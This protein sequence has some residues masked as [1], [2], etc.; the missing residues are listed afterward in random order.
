MPARDSTY[1]KRDHLCPMRTKLLIHVYCSH[2]WPYKSGVIFILFSA[3]F[4][5]NNHVHRT[6]HTLY[7]YFN[8][9]TATSAYRLKLVWTLQ[10]YRHTYTVRVYLMAWKIALESNLRTSFGYVNLRKK[11]NRIFIY[12][13]AKYCK[14][15]IIR[16]IPF[17]AMYEFCK[18]QKIWPSN[19][20]VHFICNGRDRDISLQLNNI[21]VRS[22]TSISSSTS[23]I[24]RNR[25][26]D[27][28]LQ[29]LNKTCSA[30][31]WEYKLESETPK[32]RYSWHNWW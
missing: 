3:Q 6:L 32:D 2:I 28:C 21:S 4:E 16:F 14:W 8:V 26:I 24:L 15:Q 30:S 7:G 20:H 17:L 10:K 25:M 27:E 13:K 22:S 5:Y 11:N 23:A 19:K 1:V 9:L 31:N 18:R 12:A 29:T